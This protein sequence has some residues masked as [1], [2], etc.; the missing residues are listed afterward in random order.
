M[1]L[2]MMSFSG[3]KAQE[4]AKVTTQEAFD[5]NR[6]SLSILSLN[7]LTSCDSY[8]DAW[9][10]TADFDG[11][12]DMNL[13]GTK[14]VRP[15]SSTADAVK[16]ELD[17]KYVGKQVLD[18]WL[19]YDGKK[20]DQ[21]LMEQRTRYNATDQ[22]VL[23][24]NAAKVKTLNVANKNLL[25]NSYVLVTGPT[26]VKQSKN[27]KGET[28]YTAYVDAYVYQ[29]ALTDS[30]IEEVYGNWLD[31]EATA[32]QRQRYDQTNVGLT[33]VASVKGKTGSAKTQS[34][35]ITSAFGEI[36]EPLEKKID[37]WQVV[38]SIYK[39]NPLGAK[40]GLKEGLKNSDRYRAYMVVEDMN[41]NLKYKPRGYTRATKVVDNRGNAT[42][43]SKCSE[44]YQ[45]SGKRLKEGM[46]LKQK[47]DIKLSVSAFGNFVSGYTYGG[48]DIEYLTKTSQVAGM[49]MMHYA[50]LSMGLDFGEDL[51]N[52]D[53]MYIPMSLNYGFGF[54][55]IRILEIQPNIGVGA[56]YYANSGID[57]DDSKFYESLA[58]FVR[59]GLK[60]GVQVWYPVQLF[61]RADYSYKLF[62][63]AYYIGS[64]KERFGKLSIG[65]GVKV[66]F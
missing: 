22:D 30:L 18:Y 10:S 37:K 31:E 23:K 46:F 33:L 42:G 53:A 43:D 28:I 1:A 66:N 14:G 57:T 45:I 17:G 4:A 8:V 19:Q 2:A 61:V 62:E 24:D 64:Q 54:Y 5:Y 39:K 41:G 36:L 11:K 6:C 20:F 50:G 12:F 49:G 35:A 3:L 7:G 56:D 44:F 40:I 52:E 29:V 21:K 47:K 51:Y 13:I 26:A 25:K 55:P 9:T 32:E 58:Y 27:K 65:A 48:V 60:V 59:G 34:E 63:G 38:T 15:S 16:A